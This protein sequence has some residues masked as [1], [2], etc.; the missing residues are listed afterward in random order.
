M[1]VDVGNVS[2]WVKLH[3]VLM[4][5]FS[6]DGLNVIST[7][8]STPFMLDSYTSD[9]CMHS[10][11]RSGYAR[12]MIELW[13][14][15]ELK[16]TIMMAM[17]KLVGEK[18]Y[19]CTIRVEYEW[20][21]PRCSSCKVFG[22]VLNECPKK[23]VSD[24]TK[25][26]NNPRQATRDVPVGPMVSFKSTKQVYRHVSNKNGASTGGKKK[27]AEVS[28]LEVSNSNPFDA[29]NSIENDDD[30]G[31]NGGIS[32]S[33]RKGSLNVAH[34]S[35]NNT[36]IIDKIDKSKRQIL[37]GKLMFVDDDENPLAPIGNVDSESEVE[38]VFDETT[39]LMASTSFKGESDRGY[40]TNSLLEQSRKTKRDDDYNPYDD[41][42]YES[43]DMSN[44]LQAIC[45]DLDIMYP[46]VQENPLTNG[47]FEAYT[48][49]NDD[50]QMKFDNFLKKFEQKQDDL[51]NQMRN[52]MQNLYDGPPSEDKEHEAITDT[53]LPSTED[54]QPLPLQE[55]P[56]NSNIRQLIEECCVKASEE[57]K[58]KM[59]DTMLED[60]SQISSIHS[61][62]HILSTKKPEHLLSMGYEHL[63]ITPETESDEVIESNAENLLPIP[64]KCEVTLEDE[65]ECDMPAKDVCSPVFTTFSNPLFKDNDD[66]DFSNDESLPD[67]DVPAEDFKIYSNPLFDKDEINSH[68]LDPHYFNVE[69]D[70]VES[71]LNRDTFIDFS[72]KF[73]FSSE[74][75]HIKPEIPKSDFDFEEEIRFIENLLYDNSSPRPSEEFNAEIADTIIEYIPSLSI[76][77]WDGD[78]QREEIDI[79]TETDDVLPPSVKNDD[80]YDPL[81]E[82]A[83]LFLAANHSIPPGIENFYDSEGDIR[84][85]EALLIDDSILSHESSDSNFEDN[86]SIPRPPP[87]SPDDETDVGE[88]ILV[89]MNDKAKFDENNDNSY[90][91]L[92]IFAKEFSL[93]SAESEDTIFDPDLVFH[94][95]PFDENEHLAFNVQLSPTKPEQDLSSRPSAPIIDEWVSDSEDD[96]P[97][98]SIPIAPP[99]P[100]RSNPHSK[101]SRR[102]KKA[103]FVCK[104]E[105][106]LI[107]DCNFYARK[108]AH[109]LYASRDIHKQTVS[110]VK[111]ILSMTRPKSPLRRHLSRHPSSDP[112][113]S[114]PRV[115]AAKAAVV[116]AAQ[117]KQATWVWRPKCLVLDHD[118]RTTIASMTLKRFGNPQQALKDKGVINSGCSRHMTGNISYVSDFEELNGG[119]VTFGGN[120][121]GGK[122]IGKCTIKTGKLDFDDVYFVKELKF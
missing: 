107:K 73:D 108:L 47:E 50:L 98:A 86:S 27:Q 33:A 38:A 15:V 26:L 28:R 102:T 17:P 36:P 10:W 74:L 78:S 115:I 72:S 9:M 113:N 117:D 42:L 4:T 24:V 92:V 71:L 76:P 53:E 84:F 105:D 3:G 65:I 32:M 97:Q 8:L 64:S 54:I 116:S 79:V 20:K 62:A 69:S 14:D 13:A 70:F 58:Q 118:L 46:E 122:I 22:N 43:H 7:K 100:L 23:I 87:E 12:A 119:Y 39:K 68:K 11:G 94:T 25:N 63:N 29:L 59:E 99:V 121:K 109:R 40:G 35:S 83:D 52:F 96:M 66:L 103:C 48:N 111:P 77:V 90:F 16:D 112:R 82:E 61:I 21:P 57:Q 49:A 88:E 34:G 45:D 56:Q 89:V 30:L 51:L 110:A 104:S 2:V 93:L 55:P 67:E 114:P 19:M 18:I 41:D 5:A 75:A 95:P 60:T 106:H 120:P 81:L 80:D 1:L 44:H 31:T 6:G 85:L 101:G 91:M 37:D